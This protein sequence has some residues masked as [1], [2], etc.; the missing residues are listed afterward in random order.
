LTVLFTCLAAGRLRFPAGAL[1]LLEDVTEQAYRVDRMLTALQVSGALDRIAGI[2]VGDF[3]D[4][5]PSHGVTVR[6]VLEER[7]GSLGIPVAAGLPVGHALENQ[8]FVLGM[9]ARLD[10]NAGVLETGITS[11]T[12]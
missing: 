5:P 10:A 4:C 11:E 3:S 9:P 7:L 1:L 6:D 2:V 12:A 8:P